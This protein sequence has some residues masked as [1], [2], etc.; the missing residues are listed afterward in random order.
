MPKI[1]DFN[2]YRRPELVFVMKDEAGTTLHVTTPTEQLVKELRANLRELQRTLTGHDAEATR[3]VYHLA[4]K[5]INCNLDG[6]IV[7]GDE[8]AKKYGLNLE[9]MAVFFTAYQEFIEELEHA[10]N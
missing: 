4:A 2:S 6:V 7:T 3:L 5:L 9:D 10:K 1:I 8:L